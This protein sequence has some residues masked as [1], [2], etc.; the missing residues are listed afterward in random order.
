M[1]KLLIYILFF[2]LSLSFLRAQEL[3]ESGLELKEFTSDSV[4]TKFSFAYTIRVGVDL[5]RPML[6][7]NNEDYT[8]FELVGDLRISDKLY[9]ATEI[10]NENKTSQSEQINFTT[11]GSYLKLGIDY[12]M[13]N[14]PTG[15]SNQIYCGFRIGRSAHS[16]TVNN[17]VV[18]NL[19]RFWPE[20]NS[21]NTNA[22]IKHESLS[23]SWLEIIG[24]IKTQIIKNIYMGFSLRLT[25][26]L[27][28]QTPNNFDNLFIPGYN[29]KT[30]DNNYGTAYNYTLSYSLPI[31]KKKERM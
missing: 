18:W 16:Q 21:T 17:Y 2:N 25:V 11:S 23:A 26:L 12:N 4:N 20:E 27:S 22:T 29:R 5:S 31:F 8:G 6:G 28:D 24:G 7:L 30:D 9:V 14:N 13:Y 3:Q 1:K 10:G 19:N 15:L